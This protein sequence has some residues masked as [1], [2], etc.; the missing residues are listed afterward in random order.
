MTNSRIIILGTVSDINALDNRTSAGTVLDVD[1]NQIL[2]DPGI[3]T[4]VRAGQTHIDLK[5]TNILL[6]TSTESV[7]TNDINAVIEHT[8]NIHLI[9]PKELLKHDESILTSVHAKNLKIL[10]LDK[11]ETKQTNIKNI[12]VQAYYNKSDAVSYKI[13]TSKYVIG[14]ITK[15][16][17]N[18]TFVDSFKDSNILI[19]NLT[20]QEKSK[21]LDFEE[22]TEL[23]RE[24]NPELVILNGFNKKI[25]DS[26]PLEN[27][28]KIKQEL[29]KDKEQPIKT[30]ILPA[31]EGM[32]INPEA[33]NIKLKQRSLKGFFS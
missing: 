2:I 16:K 18:K 13:T 24:V 28:R 3:G 14:Y 30:Q 4:I 11:D 33:Y 6:I 31:K 17:Y 10:S 29:Q 27:A 5:R 22:I 21:Y 20:K 19:I 1:G 8:N 32:I 15:A 25:I 12:E 26:D 23:I 7:Y 9:C